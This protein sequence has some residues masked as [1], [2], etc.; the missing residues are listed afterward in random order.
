[1]YKSKIKVLFLV[2]FVFLSIISYGHNGKIAFAYPIPKIKI[3]GKLNDWPKSVERYEIRNFLGPLVDTRAFFR[4]GYNLSEQS[5]YIAV[6]VEDN[7]NVISN[8]NKDIWWNPEDRQILYL[9][10]DHSPNRGSGV[11]GIAASQSGYVIRKV[12]NN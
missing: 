5:L 4:I 12:H 10:F 6:E 9:D 8:A 2:A 3:D 11:V 7:D 1:M